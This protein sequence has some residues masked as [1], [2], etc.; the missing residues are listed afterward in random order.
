[1]ENRKSLESFLNSLNRSPVVGSCIPRGFTAGLPIVQ[2]RNRQICLMVPYF[3]FNRA[4]E[5]DKSLVYPIKYC[6]TALWETGRIIGF[7]DLAYSE[8]FTSIDFT[9]PVGL[10][11]HESIKHLD[12]KQYREKKGEL[13]SMYEEFIGFLTDGGEFHADRQAAFISLLNTILE[14]SLAPIYK[15]LDPKFAS[16]FIE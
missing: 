16:R 11:R 9:R 6:V 10:F 3:R 15:C 12:E 14:P 2:I 8:T 4:T 1:M 5:V 7:E 13:F